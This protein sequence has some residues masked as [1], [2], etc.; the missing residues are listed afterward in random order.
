MS[1]QSNSQEA[2]DYDF[3]ASNR[4]SFEL[5][6]FAIEFYRIFYKRVLDIEM[7]DQIPLILQNSSN[8]VASFLEICANS[9][10]LKTRDLYFLIN[11]Q[12][13]SEGDVCWFGQSGTVV[14]KNYPIYVSIPSDYPTEQKLTLATEHEKNEILIRPGEAYKIRSNSKFGAEVY[15]ITAENVYVPSEHGHSD[16][17]HLCFQ[18]SAG[19]RNQIVVK[20]EKKLE[21]SINL[22]AVSGSL[23]EWR[24]LS[25]IAEDLS[26][27]NVE[28]AIFKENDPNFDKFISDKSN[29]C[30]IVASADTFFLCE[31]RVDNALYIYAEHG[32]A[33]FKGYSYSA[34]YQNYDHVLLPSNFFRSRIE[35]LHGKLKSSDVVGYPVIS[36]VEI[37]YRDIDILFAPTWSH[38]FDHIRAAQD[39]VQTCIN[40]GLR[41]AYVGHPD[42][43]IGLDQSLTEK[44][45]NVDDIYWA[46]GRSRSVVTDLSSIGIE[47]AVLGI[48]VMLMPAFSLDDFEHRLYQNGTIRVPHMEEKVWDI[49]PSVNKNNI[50]LEY[51]KL[52]TSSE[53]FSN[54][55]TE[56]SEFCHSVP[57]HETRRLCV[58]S[59]IKFIQ[60]D[61]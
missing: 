41:I 22:V 27:K 39:L 36:T 8:P 15:S 29:L 9:N 5:T 40:S 18:I 10:E 14:V 24:V 33:P 37:S 59:I 13:D 4:H 43:L 6:D 16:G 2:D 31:R 52:M 12:Y 60:P 32:V 57:V 54:A 53:Y 30:F 11:G 45:I 38:N 17:R 34:H 23:K 56:W 25:L 28:C 50:L 20:T 1:K 61:R 48:P 42:S 46:L 58:D 19:N 55:R 3:S 7:R 44:L 47:A 49:G 35:D 51:E 26:R 21:T